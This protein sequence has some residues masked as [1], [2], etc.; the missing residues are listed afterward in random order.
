MAGDW[1]KLEH[2]TIDK[3][4]V[5]RIAETLGIDQ[6]A[7]FGKCCR[8]WVWI[9]Q[10]SANGN[11]ISVTK[12]FLDRLTYAPGFADALLAVGWMSETADGF[13]IP[14][15]DRHNGKTAKKRAQTNRRVAEK[16]KGNAESVTSVTQPA[17]QKALPEKRREEKSNNTH[18]HTNAKRKRNATSVTESEQPEPHGQGLQPLI[19][20]P[21]VNDRWADAWQTW[22]ETWPGRMG[23]PF[24]PIA[25][26]FQLSELAKLPPDKAERDLAFSIGKYARSVLDSDNDFQNQN[27]KRGRTNEKPKRRRIDL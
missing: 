7:A 15:F 16:R 10:Q 26:E 25:A 6:D 9:D 3:P 8:L 12:T 4:E 2:A 23:K 1:I 22:L 19:D 20:H 17:L 13:A 21:A 18:T 5:V 11:A 14:N 27:Q 24:D